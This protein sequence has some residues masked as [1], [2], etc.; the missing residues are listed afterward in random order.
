MTHPPKSQLLSVALVIAAGFIATSECDA[1]NYYIDSVG[2]NDGNTGLS[3]NAAWK[4]HTMV[5]D[6]K[7][8]PGDT[9]G[10]ARGSAWEGGL[11]IK[12]SGA[13]GKPILFT[14]YGN[15]PLPRFSNPK[16]SDH[17]GN[18]I[19]FNGDYLIADG[20]RVLP[21]FDLVLWLTDQTRFNLVKSLPLLSQTPCFVIRFAIES[22]LVVVEFVTGLAFHVRIKS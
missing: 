15:G 4:S 11:E 22:S 9:V 10:F 3:A 20:R 21:R 5:E 13:K 2:G 6:A 16:W 18:A 19:R 12:A 8:Q 1:A 7:L 14:N 17:T